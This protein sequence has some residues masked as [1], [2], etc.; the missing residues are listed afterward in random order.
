MNTHLSTIARRLRGGVRAPALLLAALL[1]VGADARAARADVILSTQSATNSSA[2]LNFST[3]QRHVLSG[4]PDLHD[5]TSINITVPPS[6]YASNFNSVDVSHSG[7]QPDS[8]AAALTLNLS[9]TGSSRRESRTIPLNTAGAV[10]EDITILLTDGPYAFVLSDVGIASSLHG[11]GL[12]NS[13]SVTFSADFFAGTD[14]ASTRA[15]FPTD[16]GFDVLRAGVLG[17]GAY[18]L[19]ASLRGSTGAGDENS[20][21][22]VRLELIPIPEPSSAA[23][24]AVGVGALLTRF[25]WVRSRRRVAP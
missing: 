24:M 23:L 14:S 5:A 19:H 17:P 7:G 20:S 13:S 16:F 8:P 2:L 9:N 12:S 21:L 25:G 10:D 11:S 1:L 4:F 18:H 22:A 15:S 6:T 3:N